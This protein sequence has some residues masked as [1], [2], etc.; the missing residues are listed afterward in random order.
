MADLSSLCALGFSA[1]EATIA[2]DRN[3]SSVT[4]AL[5]LL[6][7]R[8]APQSESE[9]AAPAVAEQQALQEESLQEEAVALEAIYED[10]FSLVALPGGEQ[11]LRL[12]LPDLQPVAGELRLLVP[13]GTAYPT[14]PCLPLFVPSAADGA[15]DAPG[16]RVSLASA[17]AH[18][19][20]RL[21]ADVSPA[22]YELS[23]WLAEELPDFLA[24]PPPRPPP[25]LLTAKQQAKKEHGARLGA[26][27]QAAAEAASDLER[28]REREAAAHGMNFEEYLKATDAW[29][30]CQGTPDP[31]EVAALKARLA[32][33]PQAALAKIEAEPEIGG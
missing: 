1:E 7:Q 32:A 10:A 13:P 29:P 4:A 22:C 17:L 14:Q 21:A 25:L 19:A 20:A 23:A 3:G 2:L 15:L 6:L 31:I 12:Q 9:T 28:H 8:L 33:G 16:V 11:C 27:H 24:Q 5:V 18:Q 26:R 30:V